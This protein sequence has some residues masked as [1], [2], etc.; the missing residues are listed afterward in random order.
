MRSAAPV[1][2][3]GWRAATRTWLPAV[4]RRTP[5]VWTGGGLVLLVDLVVLL[6]RFVV[7][8]GGGTVPLTVPVVYAGAAPLLL[9][10]RLILDQFRLELF[11][12]GMVLCTGASVL[13]AATGGSPSITSLGLLFTLYLLWTLRA[14]PGSLGALRRVGQ[15]FVSLMVV[16][17]L[18][19]VAQVTLQLAGAWQ[20]QDYL[21]R[22]VPSSWIAQ[23]YNTNIPLSFDATTYKANAFVFLEPSFL[24]QFAA[25]AAIVAVVMRAPTWK[26]TV[27]VAGVFSAV[28]G[29]GIVLL[30]AGAVLMLVRAPHVIRPRLVVVLV[31]LMAAVL[32]SPVAALLLQRANEPA[33][34]GTS[35]YVRLVQPY[36]EVVKG[37]EADPIRYVIGA[38][39]GAAE[40]L[41][42]S[43]R[44][45][46]LGAAVVYNIIA[47]L[48]FEYGVVA[49]GV[50][51]LFIVLAI[52]DRAAWPVVPGSVIVMIFF[53][54]GS[55]LQ[56]HTVFIAWMLTGLW[57]AQSA[58]DT[59]APS[60]AGVGR[61][62]ES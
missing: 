47:K 28:S 24:S 42:T 44:A 57:T 26:V 3:S 40:R 48:A 37:L 52:L 59:P 34:A 36:L 32:A 12:I 18:V 15:G 2:L 19:G 21:G 5:A 46:Q 4:R 41:L 53:L 45:Q 30:I 35:G 58:P 55:L 1:P 6:Q 62:F 11:L 10:G 54:S 60:R 22:L 38:G 56:A 17:S 39:A 33:Q 8:A 16:L 7:P 31:G 27:L 13:S 49:G 51:L 14:V 61:A 20:Y 23:S 50:F 43:E 29:T 25:L 9:C